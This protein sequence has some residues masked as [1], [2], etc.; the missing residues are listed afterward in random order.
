VSVYR[1]KPKVFFPWE[2][3]RGL[4]TVFRR[5]RARQVL[6]VVGGVAVF[7]LLRKRELQASEVRATRAEIT[8]AGRAMAAWRADHDRPCPSSLTDLV[9][10]GYLAELPRDAWGRLLR[11]TCPGRKDPQAFDVSSD[12]PDGEPGGLDRVE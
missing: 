8:T 12:G 4:R 3:R 10:G 7:V 9:S 11:V 1:E 5:A 2:R 6:L